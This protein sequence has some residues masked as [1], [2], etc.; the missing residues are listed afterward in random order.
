MTVDADGTLQSA[1]LI[2]DNGEGPI[3]TITYEYSD[4]GVDITP[5]SWYD[6]TAAQESGS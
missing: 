4:S 6:E 2:I 3:R 5:P 1:Q